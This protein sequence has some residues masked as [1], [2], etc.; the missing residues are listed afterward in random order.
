MKEQEIIEL[1]I[2]RNEQGMNALL[3]HYGPLMRYIIAPIL[4]NVHD[5]E[6]CLSETAMQVWKNIDKFDPEWGSWNVWLTALV[7]NYALNYKR[8]TVTHQN[9]EEIPVDMPSKEPSPEEQVIQRE[10]ERALN[11]AMSQLSVKDRTLFYRKYYYMQS[12][13]QIASEMCMTERA[14][15]GKLYRIKKRLRKL[16][17]GEGYEES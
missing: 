11:R 2:S 6:D 10:R 14:V 7:R 5:Q 3:V 17:G 12:I 15:E 4:L 9:I 8:N 16:L 13:A 1:L